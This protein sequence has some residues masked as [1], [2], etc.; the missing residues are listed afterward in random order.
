MNNKIKKPVTKLIKLDGTK[1][2]QPLL[3]KELGSLKIRSGYVVLRKGENVGEH[4][5][6]NVEEMLIIL[7]GKAD[8]MVNKKKTI[9]IDK[10]SIVYLP[11]NTVHDVKNTL[12]KILRYIYVTSPTD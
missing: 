12:H 10:N 6:N 2:Y 11:P 3:K 4:T 8:V 1:K 5:T 9:K 7:E